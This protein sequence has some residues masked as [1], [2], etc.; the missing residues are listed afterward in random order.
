[1]P[2]GSRKGSISGHEHV[3]SSLA[4]GALIGTGHD[5]TKLMVARR[6]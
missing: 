4:E 6:A 3:V 5:L 1:M 2:E